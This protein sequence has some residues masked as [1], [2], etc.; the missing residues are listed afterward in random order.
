MAI[1]GPL[2][3][4]VAIASPEADSQRGEL[5]DYEA[6]LNR[7]LDAVDSPRREERTYVRI[8]NQGTVRALREAL[9][10]QRFHVLAPVVPC[11]P[12]P[13]GAGRRRGA[14]RPRRR[15]SLRC[16]GAAARP[17]RAP[18][19]ALRLFHRAA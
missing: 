13:A 7:L 15:R 1:A 4:L 8:L 5:L 6:E 16:R 18:A 9:T 17:R 10:L 3:I 12:W 19:G 14:S 11:P 2:R